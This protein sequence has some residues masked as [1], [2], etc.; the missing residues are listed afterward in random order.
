LVASFFA[1]PSI[2]KLNAILGPS[3]QRKVLGRESP[4]AKALTGSP[5]E[6]ALGIQKSLFMLFRPGT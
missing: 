2:L 4:F 6:L 5:E 3:L 1:L